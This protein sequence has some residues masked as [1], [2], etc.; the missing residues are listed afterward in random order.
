MEI[1]KIY[2]MMKTAYK[3]YVQEEANQY[4]ISIPI[5]IDNNFV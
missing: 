5:H 4:L 1:V 2:M 3:K